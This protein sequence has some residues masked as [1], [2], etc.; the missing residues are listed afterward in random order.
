MK[1]TVPPRHPKWIV[2]SAYVGPKPELKGLY[3]HT[4]FTYYK[5]KIALTMAAL[6]NKKAKSNYR[7]PGKHFEFQVVPYEHPADGLKEVV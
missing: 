6:L 5:K 7:W 4:R 2:V 1:L 3:F